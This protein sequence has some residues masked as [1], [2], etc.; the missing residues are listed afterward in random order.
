MIKQLFV[1]LCFLTI[2]LFSSS[3]AFAHAK[4]VSFDPAPRSVVSRSPKSITIL[5]NQ[6]LE[7]AYST[8]VVKNSHSKSVTDKA[9]FVDSKNNKRLVLTLPNL[10]SDKYTVSYKVLSLDGHVLESSYKFRVK[11]AVPLAD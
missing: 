2:L 9:A 11:K 3:A 4:S 6:Q 5:F 1:K 10:A 7:P 8:I